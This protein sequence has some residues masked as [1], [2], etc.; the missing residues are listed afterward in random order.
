MTARLRS[1]FPWALA[2]A[3][4]LIAAMPAMS[5]M[6]APLVPSAP[7]AGSATGPDLSVAWRQNVPLYRWSDA[8]SALHYEDTFPSVLA[9]FTRGTMHSI[10]ISGGTTMWM[11]AVWFV[12]LAMGFDII[13]KVG[14]TI[15]SVSAKLI[16]FVI[17][18]PIVWFPII[19]ALA[20]G[21]R[22]ATRGTS[23]VRAFARFFSVLALL[24][25]LTVMASGAAKST[26][27]G[28][29]NADGTVQGD[30]APYTPGDGSPGWIM[31]TT[32]G[33]IVNATA[34]IV[35]A[36]D[37][38]SFSRDS[39]YPRDQAGGEQSFHCTPFMYGLSDP[40]LIEMRSEDNGTVPSEQRMAFTL[41]ALWEQSAIPTYKAIQFGAENPYAD[42][43]FCH[44]LDQQ[45]GYTA[46][47][48][49]DVFRYSPDD[50]THPPLTLPNTGPGESGS[51]WSPKNES[52][53][54]ADMIGWAA[55][56]TG[57]FGQSWRADDSWLAN[58]SNPIGNDNGKITFGKGDGDC[59]KWWTEKREGGNVPDRFDSGSETGDILRKI[60]SSD[61]KGAQ[62]ANYALTL[63]GTSGALGAGWPVASAYLIGSLGT[64]FGI[65][66][67]AIGAVIAKI[68]AA[69][70]GFMLVAA[71]IGALFGREGWQK[72]GKS[73]MS[74]VG[75]QLFS[76][77]TLL[78]L[79]LV[80]MLSTLISTIGPAIAGAGSFLGL[81]WSGLSPIFALLAMHQLFKAMK[82]P[83]PLS[84]K[85]AQGWA[86]AL[87]GSGQAIMGGIAGGAIGSAMSNGLGIGDLMKRQQDKMTSQAMREAGYDHGEGGRKASREG[88]YD[89]TAEPRVLD[90][91]AEAEGA[92]IP[93][94]SRE[95]A[96][97]GGAEAAPVDG[98]V[99]D[100]LPVGA[101]GAAAG[102]AGGGIVGMLNRMA[103]RQVPAH[104][105]RQ[106][107][108][109]KR[110][111][112][113]QAAKAARDRRKGDY[114]G[115]ALAAGASPERAEA[116]AA[117]R[118]RKERRS[119]IAVLAARRAGLGGVLDARERRAAAAQELADQQGIP[120]DA[121]K[122]QLREQR[123][124]ELG[125][126]VL[127]GTE[128]L[129]R[130]AKAGVVG[131]GRGGAAAWRGVR[132]PEGRAK[133]LRAAANGIQASSQA[134]AKL[135]E[136][137]VGV[138]KSDAFIRSAHVASSAARISGRVALVGGLATASLATR[139]KMGMPA[140]AAALVYYKR[141][142]RLDAER[143]AKHRERLEAA[144]AWRERQKAESAAT[145]GAARID[146]PAGDTPM[147]DITPD[148]KLEL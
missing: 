80:V 9:Q 107:A 14:W 78:I 101:D 109:A 16:V 34:G 145:A 81:I 114:I 42:K 143:K 70:Y 51:L 49:F 128:K 130:G 33:V 43:V 148:G 116:I 94:E 139:G 98:I 92:A 68:L 135:R 138:S 86:N 115:E 123:R 72:V 5:A 65:G 79:S 125:N 122:R 69:I 147:F 74:M 39:L 60:N 105:E 133:A 108:K 10:L 26:G 102:L 54:R 106:A 56:E 4:I 67:F 18:T 11:V 62:I 77:A 21:L 71:V 112:D 28:A 132:T 95:G 27:P 2:V 83:S 126:A 88:A 104:E 25:L 22:A 61:P 118:M 117:G 66:V 89:P 57:D 46:Q 97:A 140:A 44:T 110:L 45:A 111:E 113:R 47:Q 53:W 141:G 15:D 52:D 13:N 59:E 35:T 84:L 1:L 120:L 131:V 29:T 76:A 24:G 6:A 3:V 137:A 119:E 144:D 91:A 50:M 99:A 30:S 121:A 58:Y 40:G 75:I 100:A 73:F 96:I 7:M 32:N 85:G 41:S 142:K 55:C 64:L 48:H 12:E 124:A 103:D 38:G 146:T 134:A 17:N 82:V 136:K 127:N 129:G 23:G 36:L 90:G 8:I 63:P 19:I 20:A 87:P 37:I 93:A 31:K